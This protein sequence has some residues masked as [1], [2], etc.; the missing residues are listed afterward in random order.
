MERKTGYVQI[1]KLAARTDAEAS[2]ATIKLL[3]RRPGRC[4][5]ITSDN[6]TE[7][8]GYADIEAASGLKFYFATPHHSWERGTN[9][10]TNGLVRQCL[11]KGKGM[12][13]LTQKQCDAVANQLN[14]RLEKDMDTKHPINASFATNQCCTSKLSLG[15][16]TDVLRSFLEFKSA[17]AEIP[18]EV[19]SEDLAQPYWSNSYF[20]ALDAASLYCFIAT[21]SSQIPVMSARGFG[22]MER[23][24]VCNPCLAIALLANLVELP[25]PISM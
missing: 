22:S 20:E 5:T 3:K 16:Y 25:L 6:G 12:T 13:G 15:S 18:F 14:N 7:F 8:H 1:G 17:L 2:R 11:P 9:E 24:C 19:N 21:S 10:N 4:Q 23:I